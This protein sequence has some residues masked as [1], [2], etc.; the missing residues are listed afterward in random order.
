MLAGPPKSTYTA[1]WDGVGDEVVRQFVTRL[2]SQ[3][4]F[5]GVALL[6]P[7]LPMGTI[8][9]PVKMTGPVAGVAVGSTLGEL[10]GYPC[11]WISERYP[12]AGSE[13]GFR[14]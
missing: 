8:G 13:F 7:P 11:I 5:D 6:E 12:S 14:K 4:D 9:M 1:D 3:I 2:P 10:P